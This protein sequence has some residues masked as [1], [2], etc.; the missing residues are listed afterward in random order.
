MFFKIKWKGKFMKMKSK[1]FFGLGVFWVFGLV[2]TG[3]PTNGSDEPYIGPK[4]IK[5]T[6]YS[7]Q[8]ITAYDMEI[9]SES[10]GTD[11]W[12]HTAWA[13]EVID[14]QTITYTVA[15]WEDHWENPKPW[16][17]TGKFFIVIE[18]KPPNDES[19]DGAKYVY[20]V[21]GTNATLVDIKYQ[22]TTLEWAKFIWLKDY[23]AG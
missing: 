12:S 3:C 13:P 14:G 23:T 8:D 20:S 5:I 22:V 1:C 10:T 2:L 11:G 16:T 21:D 7:L 18:C 6:G 4:T 9:Y 19:Q 17:G 15:N